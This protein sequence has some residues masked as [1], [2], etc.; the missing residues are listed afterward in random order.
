MAIR[1]YV[2]TPRGFLTLWGGYGCGKTHLLAS[3][4]N[5]CTRSAIGAVYYTLPDMLD[6]LRD[7]FAENA[8]DRRYARMLSVRVLVIDEVD[9]ARLTDWAKEQ[10]FRL[11]DERYRMRHQQGTVFA[12]NV[13]PDARDEQLGYLYSRMHDGRII[14]MTADDIRRRYE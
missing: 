6:V 4:V 1:D 11:V 7:A 14:H 5:E 12:M 13:P 9:K 2:H 8:Y 10:L 3:L